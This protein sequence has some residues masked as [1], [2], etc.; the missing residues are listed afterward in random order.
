MALPSWVPTDARAFLIGL[1][2]K[3]RDTEIDL[4]CTPH[5][6]TAYS[7]MTVG[8][9]VEGS[10]SGHLVSIDE[11]VIWLELFGAV[12]RDMAL[13]LAMASR[14]QAA[15]AEA[16]FF[17]AVLFLL[18]ALMRKNPHAV[19]RVYSIADGTLEL[20]TAL[21]RLEIENLEGALQQ[22]SVQLETAARVELD[23]AIL[24]ELAIMNRLVAGELAIPIPTDAHGVAGATAFQPD[25]KGIVK[26]SFTVR[27]TPAGLR[28]RY[29]TWARR[30]G[31]LV[32]ADDSDGDM[33]HLGLAHGPQRFDVFAT[34]WL[35]GEA[36]LM[37][38]L[39][40]TVAAHLELSADLIAARAKVAARIAAGPPPVPA[41][42]RP[43]ISTVR[44]DDL[45]RLSSPA[46]LLADRG[47]VFAVHLG[48]LAVFD[49]VVHSVDAILDRRGHSQLAGIAAIDDDLLITDRRAGELVRVAVGIGAVSVIAQGLASP[50]HIVRIGALV[51]VV[52][53][54]TRVRAIEIASGRT[55]SELGPFPALDKIEALAVHGDAL[56]AS[57]A[58]NIIR[59]DRHANTATVIAELPLMVQGLASNRGDLYASVW[60]G[61]V[62]VDVGTGTFRQVAGKELFT[63]GAD[64]GVV[65]LASMVTPARLTSDETGIWFD[66]TGRLRRLDLV[67]GYVT[68]HVDGRLPI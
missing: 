20:G 48:Q 57:D 46:A 28:D 50:S 65:E 44:G 13:P 17:A 52:C 21:R 9:E 3:V 25:E 12:L 31:W 68:T 58:R 35:D 34:R 29:R 64:D 24:A 38:H 63:P 30:D 6:L 4:A 47:L 8:D 27:A 62:R 18:E 22:A 53:Q 43:R 45:P 59:I 49:P 54:P 2:S 51:Y 32:E 19:E 41:V 33:L 37:F 56:Y 14:P 40:E 15:D 23:P 10:G 60:G 5:V 36:L 55:D 66:D 11:H 67:H 16:R 26:A 39:G 42:T 1:L 7:A 61:I